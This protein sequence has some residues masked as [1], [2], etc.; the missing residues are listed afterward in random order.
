M[1]GIDKWIL[2]PGIQRRKLLLSLFKDTIL[3]HYFLCRIYKTKKASSF[4]FL[5]AE[6]IILTNPMLLLSC[7][8]LV[9]GFLLLNCNAKINQPCSCFQ[10][11]YVFVLHLLYTGLFTKFFRLI[12]IKFIILWKTTSFFKI[13]FQKTI[14]VVLSDG[15]ERKKNYSGNNCKYNNL[16]D[17]ISLLFHLSFIPG[18]LSKMYVS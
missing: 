18:I 2:V 4:V 9:E 16:A 3:V 7:N 14:S 5:I 12:N 10:I 15:H 13:H 17:H 8:H 6:A 1:I 11:F